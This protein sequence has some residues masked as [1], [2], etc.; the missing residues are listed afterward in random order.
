[1]VDEKVV[2]MVM[3]E[4][5]NFFTRRD[6]V[7]RYEG[8]VVIVDQEINIS[9]PS[10]YI[11]IRGSHRNDGL[12]YMIDEHKIKPVIFQE[13]DKHPV[14]ETFNGRVWFCYPTQ[15]FLSLCDRITSFQVYQSQ[16]PI[17][18]VVSESFGQSSRTFAQGKNGLITWKEQY[19]DSL[20]PYRNHMFE[21][22]W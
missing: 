2:Y 6:D 22:V 20:R 16:T 9:V 15:D 21:E 4:V 19:G 17:T 1:M 11:I 3:K 14:D 7:T 5:C 10:P 8:N 13:G 12:Y 18:D